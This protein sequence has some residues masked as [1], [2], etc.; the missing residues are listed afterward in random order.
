MQVVSECPLRVASVLWRA[1]NGGLFL[2][3][4]CK[5][6][7]SLR[8]SVSP[9][10][11]EHEDLNEADSYWDDDDER[12]SL[13]A[14][15]DLAPM[16]PR[17]DVLLVGHA[18][19][20]AGRP[21]EALSARLAV[22]TISKTIDVFGDRS[23]SQDGRLRGPK[24]FVKMSLRWERAAGGPGTPNP[25]GVAP[26]MQDPSGHRVL[27]N[28]QPP[29]LPIGNNSEVIPAIGF[30]PI[31]PTWPDRAANLHRHAAGWDHARWHLQPL[32]DDIDPAFFNA[33]PPDQQIKGLGPDQRI[34]L[35]NLHR[36]HPRLV[37]SLGGFVPR[38][39]IRRPG[40]RD[41]EL[42][43]WCDTLYI[44]TDRQTCSLTWRGWRELRDPHEGGTVVIA[45]DGTAMSTTPRDRSETVFLRLDAL[46]LAASTPV[47]PF[48]MGAPGPAAPSDGDG[49]ARASGG[50]TA[51]AVHAPVDRTLTLPTRLAPAEEPLPFVRRAAEE[52]AAT[53]AVAPPLA[54]V[55]EDPRDEPTNPP[56]SLEAPGLPPPPPRI[57]PLAHVVEA[58]RAGAAPASDAAPSV[59]QAP[60]S[61]SPARAEAAAGAAPA[62]PSADG[63]VTSFDPET[64]PIARYAAI[65][66]EIYERRAP[67]ERILRAH[68]LTEG[69]WVLAE[70]HWTEAIEKEARRGSSRLRHESDTA[71]VAAV[72]GFRGQPIT[73]QEYAR[74][75]IAAERGTSDELLDDLRIQRP[76]L[77]PIV[78]LWTKKIATEPRLAGEAVSL[79]SRARTA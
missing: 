42:R 48:T 50:V 75:V 12:R 28:L 18:Y 45:E 33:A 49:T 62:E 71:H 26:A 61:G 36:E 5:A 53:V 13:S 21:V 20:P 22:G 15:T 64:V 2:T 47:L 74:I 79:L 43:I 6:T 59:A 14:P 1:P 19:A 39:L 31:A 40:K 10:A 24:E 38:A 69:T 72:E 32:P 76:A 4:A 55:A 60:A 54:P 3:V 70:R 27:P 11:K 25:V 73:V 58:A 16:K 57:G 8:P 7:Y 17:A 67:R 23:L 56:P 41:E 37:T 29:G 30:G 65:L 66:A 51:R 52:R 77:M 34:S 35:D 78:R 68:E 63:A 9:L 44:D 46:A